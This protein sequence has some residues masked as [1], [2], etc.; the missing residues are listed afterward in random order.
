[1]S[2]TKNHIFIEDFYNYRDYLNNY[3]N[4]AKIKNRQFS[5]GAWSKKLGL[6]STA[7]L[8]K[9]LSGE[10]EITDLQID[11]LVQYFK[12]SKQEELTFRSLVSIS[13]MNISAQDKAYLCRKIYDSKKNRK[14]KSR[15]IALDQFNLFANNLPFA[16]YELCKLP[17]IHLDKLAQLFPQSNQQEITDSVKTLN[18]L[19]LISISKENFV[20][21]QLMNLETSDDFPSEAI[22]HYHRNN[23]KQASQKIDSIPVEFREFQSLL[24]LMNTQNLNQYKEIIR[25]FVNSVESTGKSDQV[26]QLYSIQ[27]QLFPVS[28]S[29]P[30]TQPLNQE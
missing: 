14:L 15:R 25:T 13:K 6:K 30:P 4:A 12:F 9:V 24:F 19:S 18:R 20:H 27:V 2:D 7:A 11:K 29:F 26:N 10:R 21:S 5:I 16:I 1:M 28:E 17:N 22:K 23:F 3:L 8:S